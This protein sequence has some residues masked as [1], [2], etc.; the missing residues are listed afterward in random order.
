MLLQGSLL[1]LLAVRVGKQ[2]Y[3]DK[4]L[5]SKIRVDSEA[6]LV[7]PPDDDVHDVVFLD[8]LGALVGDLE[9]HLL[10]ADL[11]INVPKI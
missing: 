10:F 1:K 11:K 8:F 7:Y 4:G 6:V 3:W 9:K 5:G 2:S